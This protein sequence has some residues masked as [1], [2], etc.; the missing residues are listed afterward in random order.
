MK[1][2]PLY[3]CRRPAPARQSRIMPGL[4]LLLIV[5]LSGSAPAGEPITGYQVAL[6][7]NGS[8]KDS[9]GYALG[10]NLFCYQYGDGEVAPFRWSVILSLKKSTKGFFSTYFFYDRPQAFGPN[11]RFSFYVEYKR[12]LE[13]DYYGLGND[14]MRRAAY[15][16]PSDKDF[17][18]KSYYSFQQRW[19]SLFIYFQ[20]PSF[21]RHTRNL[22]SAGFYERKIGGPSPSSKLAE[23]APLGVNGGST[24]IFQYGFIYDT[25][26]QEATPRHGAWSEVIAEYAAPL[27]GSD[28]NYLR[29]TLTD[30][31]YISITPRLVYAHRMLFEPIFGDVPFY[32]MAMINSSFERHF[33]LGGATSLRGVPRLLFVGQHKLLGN[34]ELRFET[35]KMSILKQDFTFFIHTFV[36]AGRVWLKGDSFNLKNIH[37]SYGVGLHVL[38]QKDLIGAIDIGRSQFSN[39]AVYITFRNLF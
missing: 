24:H 23:D 13:D 17:R 10:G 39:L 16:N 32:D 2:A 11:S 26:D 28:Y 9:E 6:V 25:R 15:L 37:K 3:S 21:F 36:D 31:R 18:N 5:V 38:W 20:T 8:Y 29:L 1:R 30:R 14:S 34:F 35:L 33:G 7:P 27:L 19:P 4:I 22:F 12:Y